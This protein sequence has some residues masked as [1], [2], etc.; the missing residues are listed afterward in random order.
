MSKNY[1]NYYD[2]RVGVQ[3]IHG[4]GEV[5]EQHDGP[6]FIGY[7]KNVDG[8]SVRI[9]KEEYDEQRRAERIILARKNELLPLLAKYRSGI[10]F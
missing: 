3:R 5:W 7:Y 6:D 10:L 8:Q 4:E 2:Y 1:C 9:T